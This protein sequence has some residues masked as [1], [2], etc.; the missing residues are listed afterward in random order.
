M[1]SEAGATTRSSLNE[2]FQSY[3]NQHKTNLLADFSHA[4][5]KGI[6][7]G[8]L[9]NLDPEMLATNRGARVRKNERLVQLI[10]LAKILKAPLS[11]PDEL[12]PGQIIQLHCLKLTMH[13]G[14]RG[15]SSLRVILDDLNNKIT[16][17]NRD[18]NFIPLAENT[19]PENLGH[20]LRSFTPLEAYLAVLA[21]T[22]QSF[23]SSN[24]PAA[25][26]DT[27]SNLMKEINDEE[28]KKDSSVDLFTK[29]RNRLKSLAA[30]RK[31]LG[32][33]LYTQYTNLLTRLK[34]LAQRELQSASNS[35]ISAFIGSLN[36]GSKNL[37]EIESN[38]LTSGLIALVEQHQKTS[39]EQTEDS[40]VINFAQFWLRGTISEQ[41]STAYISVSASGSV[42]RTSTVLQF[43]PRHSFSYYRKDFAQIRKRAEA[44]HLLPTSR[45]R[46]QLLT[47][48]QMAATKASCYISK[49]KLERALIAYLQ[50]R[51]PSSHKRNAQTIWEEF[52]V[53]ESSRQGLNL[54][55][56]EQLRLLSKV[57][58]NTTSSTLDKD[59]Q[60]AI[61]LI[62]KTISEGWLK[63]TTRSQGELANLLSP[64]TISLTD[65]E[66][67]QLDKLLASQQGPAPQRI[68]H[69]V[70]NNSGLSIRLGFSQEFEPAPP[71]N[72][73]PPMSIHRAH[74][75]LSTTNQR[76]S[77]RGT[78]D[79]DQLKDK[80]RDLL[81]EYGEKLLTKLEALCG[82][83]VALAERKRQLTDKLSKFENQLR[84][85]LLR[86]EPSLIG[87]AFPNYFAIQAQANQN[88]TSLKWATIKALNEFLKTI[89]DAITSID[90]KINSLNEVYLGQVGSKFTEINEECKNLDTLSIAGSERNERIALNRQIDEFSQKFSVHQATCETYFKNL[91]ECE[92]LLLPRNS[93][94]AQ[95]EDVTRKINELRLGTDAQATEFRRRVILTEREEHLEDY[96]RKL[97]TVRNVF[98]THLEL[99]DKMRELSLEGFDGT[100]Q[101]EQFKATKWAQ[102]HLICKLMDF[103]GK[104]Q[105]Y[106]L[107]TNEDGTTATEA[108]TDN[109][110]FQ[111]YKKVVEDF[112]KQY[113]LNA[114]IRSNETE[115]KNFNTPTSEIANDDY[116]QRIFPLADAFHG[117]DNLRSYN[118]DDF[119][120]QLDWDVTNLKNILSSN[121]TEPAKS[122]LDETAEKQL[123]EL[124]EIYGLA[125]RFACTEGIAQVKTAILDNEAPDETK[126]IV[127][128]D[129]TAM[130]PVGAP[131]LKHDGSTATRLDQLAMDVT[132]FGKAHRQYSQALVTLAEARETA[133][134]CQAEADELAESEIVLAQSFLKTVKSIFESKGKIDPTLQIPEQLKNDINTMKGPMNATYLEALIAKVNDALA[135]LGKAPSKTVEDIVSDINNVLKTEYPDTSIPQKAM[136]E[137]LK[138][139]KNTHAEIMEPV[140]AYHKAIEVSTTAQGQVEEKHRLCETSKAG[141][142]NAYRHIAS[143]MQCFMAPMLL[144][145]AEAY[146]ACHRKWEARAKASGDKK[147]IAILPPSLEFTVDQHNLLKLQ[148]VNKWIE[149]LKEKIESTDTSSESPEKIL[150]NQ[151]LEE[152]TSLFSQLSRKNENA[153]LMDI[154]EQANTEAASIRQTLEEAELS[155]AQKETIKQANKETIKQANI[156]AASIRQILEEAELSPA[157]QVELDKEQLHRYRLLPSF[158]HQA[159]DLTAVPLKNLE[160]QPAML[161]Y[162][163]TVH[164][165]LAADARQQIANLGS[166]T[167][168]GSS[169]SKAELLAEF[170]TPLDVA[171]EVIF[172]AQQDTGISDKKPARHILLP[173]D[174][175]IYACSTLIEVALL[176]YENN[177]LPYSF[178][179]ETSKL[180]P[181]DP[182]LAKLAIKDP[183]TAYMP[184]NDLQKIAIA[185]INETK[186]YNP[187]LWMLAH[188]YCP[189][190]DPSPASKIR[191]DI[192][193]CMLQKQLMGINPSRREPFNKAVTDGKTVEAIINAQFT[194]AQLPPP[195]SEPAEKSIYDG[196][197]E[198]ILPTIRDITKLPPKY[199]S[200]QSALT[201]DE[202]PSEYLLEIARYK[203][204]VEIACRYQRLLKDKD[205]TSPEFSAAELNELA[206]W[207]HHLYKLQAQGANSLREQILNSIKKST[208]S[209]AAALICSIMK[210]PASITIPKEDSFYTEPQREAF[211]NLKARF[212]QFGTRAPDRAKKAIQ[213]TI[214]SAFKKSYTD[215]LLGFYLEQ[216]P[217][218]FVNRLLARPELMGRATKDHKEALAMIQNC[219]KMVLKLSTAETPTLKI[220]T[221]PKASTQ[222]AFSA[223]VGF[224]SPPTPSLQVYHTIQFHPQKPEDAFLSMYTPLSK[225][226][227]KQ[228]SSADVETRNRIARSASFDVEPHNQMARNASLAAL[229]PS[230]SASPSH[231]LKRLSLDLELQAAYMVIDSYFSALDPKS[232]PVQKY[233]A[234]TRSTDLKP[235][236]VYAW[237]REVLDS[238][239][240]AHRKN[241]IRAIS[242][243]TQEILKNQGSRLESY[244]GFIDQIEK[245]EHLLITRNL[246]NEYLLNQKPQLTPKGHRDISLIHVTKSYDYRRYTTTGN[247]DIGTQLRYAQDCFISDVPLR[248]W[249]KKLAEQDGNYLFAHTACLAQ[250]QGAVGNA[251]LAEVLTLSGITR[252]NKPV[253]ILVNHGN[254][255]FTTLVVK[256]PQHAEGPY[257]VYHYDSMGTPR[258]WVEEKVSDYFT[259]QGLRFDYYDNG[260]PIYPKTSQQTGEGTN[261]GLYAILNGQAIAS[262]ATAKD[263]IV[264]LSK[265]LTQADIDEQCQ[266]DKLRDEMLFRQI[267]VHGNETYSA[268]IHASQ[269][270]HASDDGKNFPILILPYGE[271]PYIVNNLGEHIIID[272]SSPSA[273]SPDSIAGLAV[274]YEV[275]KKMEELLHDNNHHKLQRLKRV[276]DGNII[277]VVAS[278][279]L[280]R[281]N[282]IGALNHYKQTIDDIV[283]KLTVYQHI[284]CTSSIT[285][286]DIQGGGSGEQA[287]VAPYRNLYNLLKHTLSENEFRVLV[288]MDRF[289]NN[290]PTLSKQQSEDHHAYE[291][292]ISGLDVTAL[293][294][295]C[296]DVCSHQATRTDIERLVQIGDDIRHTAPTA[297]LSSTP[298]T[299]RGSITDG[300]IIAGAARSPS[301]T[302]EA[303]S[304]G[305]AE[306]KGGVTVDAATSVQALTLQIENRINQQLSSNGNYQA[307]RQAN[308]VL[309][310]YIGA[311]VPSP[312]TEAA[313]LQIYF[314][315]EANPDCKLL[316]QLYATHIIKEAN[317]FA[318]KFVQNKSQDTFTQLYGLGIEL[319]DL[320]QYLTTGKLSEARTVAAKISPKDPDADTIKQYLVS[321]K[322]DV[323]EERQKFILHAL[324]KWQRIITPEE[325]YKGVPGTT[326]GEKERLQLFFDELSNSSAKQEQPSERQIA[327]INQ[328]FK[329]YLEPERYG[330]F[331][332]T[333]NPITATF[334][335]AGGELGKSKNQQYIVL[336][337]AYNKFLDGLPTALASDQK[338]KLTYQFF[339]DH[340]AYIDIPQIY[341][342]ANTNSS[343]PEISEDALT[344]VLAKSKPFT[345]A[346]ASGLPRDPLYPLPTTLTSAYDSR[347][348][349]SARELIQRLQSD[350]EAFSSKRTEA[351]VSSIKE[352]KRIYDL[353]LSLNKTSNKI[354]RN[355]EV[356]LLRLFTDARALYGA[357]KLNPG[358]LEVSNIK[359]FTKTLN[360]YCKSDKLL[361]KLGTTIVARIANL[362]ALE[363]ENLFNSLPP[364]HS[365]MLTNL[366]VSFNLLSVTSEK[367]KSFEDEAGQATAHLILEA[368]VN[369]IEQATD[370]HCRECWPWE[371]VKVDTIKSLL[372]SG[373]DTESSLCDKLGLLATRMRELEAARS[374]GSSRGIRALIPKIYKEIQQKLEELQTSH[375]LT[376]LFHTTGDSKFDMEVM[377]HIPNMRDYLKEVFSEEKIRNIRQLGIKEFLKYKDKD[378]KWQK[379]NTAETAIEQAIC[380]AAE[381]YLAKR[382][383][384]KAQR[385]FPCAQFTPNAN[386]TYTASL[387]DTAKNDILK[388]ANRLN[389]SLF[390]ELRIANNSYLQRN[391]KAFDCWRKALTNLRLPEGIVLTGAAQSDGTLSISID[392]SQVYSSSD[393]LRTVF[394]FAHSEGIH[395]ESLKQGLK[396]VHPSQDKALKIIKAVQKEKAGEHSLFASLTATTSS[397]NAGGTA[398][399]FLD[400]KATQERTDALRGLD[401]PK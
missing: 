55:H 119:L 241:W 376:F 186:T 191:R 97:T 367:I 336:Q 285:Q 22:Q 389:Q 379:I 41:L 132:E 140:L 289:S 353:A 69:A 107:F 355:D 318:Y 342:A 394:K 193:L 286:F 116:S 151:L 399:A 102:F 44:Y 207:Q 349:S 153:T 236:L 63:R 306:S 304:G 315:G 327:L 340:Q 138:L 123:Q 296:R 244:R 369:A 237:F 100:S 35:A 162:A 8:N 133:T 267:M 235:V 101:T 384:E 88:P 31:T 141:M 292:R 328:I 311:R 110:V 66:R 65:Q 221:T 227:S 122:F 226:S 390:S 91:T 56:I 195:F 298:H 40:A 128:Q 234:A 136:T 166:A 231:D 272:R 188:G 84:Q 213:A 114:D 346:V 382:G 62:M 206:I 204:C 192:V 264:K 60:K 45:P 271:Q 189:K 143:T 223:G 21:Y 79:L 104:Y 51:L 395:Y 255:H 117:P 18:I 256:P 360:E 247:Y 307:I 131:D 173:I 163:L 373:W 10:L 290:P 378:A 320:K 168:I 11:T 253:A 160:R 155:R 9:A 26:E 202:A 278:A 332:Q 90:K 381:T 127:I 6:N 319:S 297:P 77:I 54:T 252:L 156:E 276:N 356:E 42:S 23:S 161:N 157:L 13:A 396:Q 265:S 112:N 59:S 303:L 233:R 214:S 39:P 361:E 400:P 205:S 363:R 106:G 326:G 266:A 159:H 183:N 375:K 16:Q 275:Y 109:R 372:T 120:E 14:G 30:E 200:L 203:D 167:L 246:R 149:L 333:T 201:P 38:I 180:P 118:Q 139:Y 357:L 2:Q 220:T 374:P 393:D 329:A 259:G 27:F 87:A 121:V 345:I 274:S 401:F 368:V 337:K 283:S 216:D 322:A 323:K 96:T 12:T 312:T 321:L 19:L 240:E 165:V 324:T 178:T 126:P 43:Q 230:S 330:A 199:R 386:G 270:G 147:A 75:T 215:H 284:Q 291:R 397:T 181:L 197:I 71:V 218:G 32:N 280:K 33:R 37:W 175:K 295:Q 385:K 210:S 111:K 58:Q 388:A 134:E 387:V 364:D 81:T 76:Q 338:T 251:S 73:S 287:Y 113:S 225:P 239:D 4:E 170:A 339:V 335:D 82:I 115:F 257:Q 89:Q 250:T 146:K 61:Y 164:Q 282:P 365:Q 224:K 29:L 70:Q 53:T 176:E 182:S 174:S 95:E 148:Q 217:I 72:P 92:N 366:L 28:N 358:S 219:F 86:V 64:V 135:N 103:V 74:A 129:K 383:I 248:L 78:L 52:R 46:R 228:E 211:Q 313:L 299:P 359:S 24:Q 260:A 316:Q 347:A 288:V 362:P 222:P 334:R 258:P 196:Y 177:Q 351:S 144:I 391:H 354:I 261:C 85:H 302:T 130:R 392:N 277:D 99:L 331:N 7:W 137:L 15:R 172:A 20:R 343:D 5:R 301:P 98:H 350:E 150:L 370:N 305:V 242:E 293:Y 47:P 67:A 263:L 398:L 254:S 194:I 83:K 268:A 209:Q 50:H 190:L 198:R 310:T 341:K 169:K 57:L 185:L 294:D 352:E 25:A 262:T 105:K 279:I 93:L 308:I 229:T 300:T 281:Q 1:A 124:T 34:V 243:N 273:I 377:E 348:V 371:I 94:S 17:P 3:F 309:L 48:A 212:D 145:Q 158:Y 232:V 80:K 269:G 238:M 179:L 325:I 125:A 171:D 314:N 317:E 245:I 344:E 208:I 142:F 36:D 184:G 49:A 380:T 154:S 68:Q 152:Q 187:F 249:G 108:L